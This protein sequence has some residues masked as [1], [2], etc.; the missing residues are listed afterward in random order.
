MKRLPWIGGAGLLLAC[1]GCDATTNQQAK[2]LVQPDAWVGRAMEWWV[3]PAGRLEEAGRI[4]T[5]RRI[6]VE[7]GVEIDCWLIKS[8]LY[9]DEAG[10]RDTLFEGRLTRGTVVLLHPLMTGKAWFLGVGERLADRGWDVLLLDL[11]G[12]GYS[13]GRFTTWG[14]REKRDVKKVVDEVLGT[15]GVSQDVYVCGS[16][17]GGGVAI[18]YAAIDPR[19]RGVV[20]VS[21]PAGAVSVFRRILCLLAEPFFQRA[22]DRAGELADFDPA[23]ASALAAAEKLQCPLVVVHGSWDC[24]VPF[25]HGE[26]I[27]EAS[28]APQKKLIALPGVGH[29]AEVGRTGWL[30]ERIEEVA[31]MSRVARRDAAPARTVARADLPSRSTDGR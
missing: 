18:Q 22:V 2:L 14:A 7:P 5:H 31:D 19:C 11:R 10:N 6:E 29:V 25:R 1:V 9:D 21:P 12:H 8:R 26:R 20:A 28:S 17:M 24:I 30:T 16:S 15:E 27:F 3:D 23:D 4:D 13:G